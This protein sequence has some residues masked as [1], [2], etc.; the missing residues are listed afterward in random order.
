[1]NRIGTCIAG[2]AITAAAALA[3]EKTVMH[4][5]AFTPIETATQVEW[6][7]YWKASDALP[8]QIPGL[9]RV[10]HGKLN[11]PLSQ[12]LLKFADPE[13]GKK[14]RADKKGTTEFSIVERKHGACME[15]DNLQAFQSYGAHPAHKTWVDAYAK[16][17]V[18]GT[19]TY[20]IIPD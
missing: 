8:G 18:E 20:Q 3:G 10:W 13:A 7:A 2:I 19:T 6:D 15:F 14:M 17:R 12:N 4:C 16:V 11:R 1:M 9:K 5:F